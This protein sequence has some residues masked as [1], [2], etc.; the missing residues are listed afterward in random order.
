MSQHPEIIAAPLTIWIAPVGTAFPEMTA[1][2][3]APW[4]M[5]GTNGARNYA[6]TGVVVEHQ[7]QWTSPPPPAGATATNVVMLESED[8]RLRVELLDLALE[9]YSFVLGS[10]E[11]TATPRLPGVAGTRA[12][13]LSI[14]A[15]N[16]P[17]FALLA[18]GPSPYVA[19][20][21]SQYQVPRCCEAGSPS[22]SRRKGIPAGLSI[23]LRVLPDPAATSEAERFGRLIAQDSTAIVPITHEDGRFLLTSNDLILE[24]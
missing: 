4:V 8:M 5:L 24:I 19:G 23:D 17:E 14:G 16:V 6:G 15:G 13:G 9:Q 1:E 18:R 21:L 2:P 20:L 22:L 10:N 12:I 3:G 11:I 7:R